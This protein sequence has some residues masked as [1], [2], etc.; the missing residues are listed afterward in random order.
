MGV[1]LSSALWSPS[2]QAQSSLLMSPKAASPGC[3]ARCIAL[4]LNY[5]AAAPSPVKFPLLY[6]IVFPRI[7]R[8]LE[9]EGH[10]KSVASGR[11]TRLATSCRGREKQMGGHIFKTLELFTIRA[12]AVS[13][14]TLACP[15]VNWAATD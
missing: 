3:A 4:G 6:M 10:M 1:S 5:T 12:L 13:L 7:L 9:M 2:L 15:L 14:L 11:E 8:L